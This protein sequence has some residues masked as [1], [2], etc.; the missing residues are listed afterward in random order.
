MTAV[1]KYVL[2]HFVEVAEQSEEIVR[3]GLDDFYDIISD[4]MLNTKDEEPVWECCLRW[5]DFDP[6]TRKPE[7]THL[8]RGIRLGLL[9]TPV[10]FRKW[11]GGRGCKK[12][13]IY[14][15]WNHLI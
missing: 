15:L 11:K 1:R 10:G 14:I 8:L 5:I 9:P 2:R 6:E 7:V 13:Y 3:I 4:D 12:I